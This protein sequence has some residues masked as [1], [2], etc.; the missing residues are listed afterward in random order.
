M[1]GDI[2]AVIFLRDPFET[3]PQEPDIQAMLRVCDIHNVPLA[4]NISAA[5]AVLHLIFEHPEA[6]TGHHLAAQYIE[7]MAAIHDREN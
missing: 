7:E 6:I 4:T 2:N 5:E 1:N 3:R